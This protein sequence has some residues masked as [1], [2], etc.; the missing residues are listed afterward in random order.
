MDN[1]SIYQITQMS[2]ADTKSFLPEHNFR[3]WQ[4]IQFQ[5]QSMHESICIMSLA[6][7]VNSESESAHDDDDSKLII[8]EELL[9]QWS[10]VEHDKITCSSTSFV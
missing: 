4:T 7:S 2:T 10:S 5:S 1:D 6:R 3:L 8:S 9:R